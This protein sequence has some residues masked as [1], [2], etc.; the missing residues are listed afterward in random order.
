MTAEQRIIADISSNHMGNISIAKAMID[1]AGRIGVDTVKFQSWRSECLSTNFMDYETTY[2]RHKSTELS[3]R[4]HIDLLQHC[5]SSG[6]EFLTTCFDLG[7]VDF[8][9]ELGL[10]AIKV[11]SPDCTSHKLIKVLMDKFP[12]LI[13]STGMTPRSEVLKTINLVRGHDVTFLHCTSVYPTPPSQM[14]L[15]RMDWLKDQGVKVGF[16]DHSIGTVGGKIALARGAEVLEKHFTL[17]RDLPGKDQAM[18]T[19][20][21]EFEEL[22]NFKNEML[23]INGSYDADILE[24]ELNIRKIYVG[25]WGDNS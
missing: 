15:R 25:K 17:S 23:E 21:R 9:S 8:L 7:R 14:N 2:A 6:V 5:N 10:N 20:P 1:V 3:D 24:E 19:E 18:S 22:V 4:D 13:I 12:K 11:A 16:S